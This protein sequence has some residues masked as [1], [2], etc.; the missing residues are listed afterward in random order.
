MSE[1]YEWVHARSENTLAHAGCDFV[2]CTWGWIWP[3]D[4]DFK[5]DWSPAHRDS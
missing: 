1:T 2:H 4:Q 5:P 3:G